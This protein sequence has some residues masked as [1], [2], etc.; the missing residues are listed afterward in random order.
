MLERYVTTSKLKHCSAMETLVDWFYD[1]PM[2]ISAQEYG[3]FYNLKN[4]AEVTSNDPGSVLNP[5]ADEFE[6]KSE[7][8]LDTDSVWELSPHENSCPVDG[9]V[10]MNGDIGKLPSGAVFATTPEPGAPIGPA[11][12]YSTLNGAAEGAEGFVSPLD[13]ISPVPSTA[14]SESST[15]P[16]EQLKQML[17]SQLEY[18]FSRENLANDAYLISQMDNDQYV[19]IW[20]VA[21]FNQVKKLTKDIKLIT[22][23]LRESPNVQV[24]E[25]GIKVRPNHKR[26]IV[27]LR[28]IPDNTPLEEVKNLF[29]GENCPRLISC[30]FAHNSSWY[31]TFESDEDAQ[32]A[33]RFLRE[34]VREFQGR[35][36]MARIKAK[37]M[38]RLPL[39]PVTNV[40]NGFRNTPPP[41]AVYDPTAF[42]PGQQ[43]FV[44]SNGTP[45]PP[46]SVSFA[47]QVH[48][49]PYQQ[50]YPGVLQAWPPAS[51][52]YYDIGSV[53]SVNGLAPQGTF[54][55]APYRT[56]P[57][58][59]NKQRNMSVQNHSQPHPHAQTTPHSQPPLQV[60]PPYHQSTSGSGE[61]NRDHVG[62]AGRSAAAP[63]SPQAQVK[64][65]QRQAAH[66]DSSA[67]RAALG[68]DG[69]N[70]SVGHAPG[71]MSGRT[72]AEDVNMVLRPSPATSVGNK[73]VLP[74][75]HRRGRRKD[76]DLGPGAQQSQAG[77]TQRDA[78]MSRGAQFDLE[79]AAFPPL[80]GLDSGAQSS[81][82]VVAVEAPAVPLEAHWGENRLADVVKGTV[83]V[84]NVSS[85]LKEV[86]VSSAGPA[87][88]SESPRALSPHQT[89]QIVSSTD[90]I[91]N[92]ATPASVTA[93]PVIGVS[94]EQ[95]A[96]D[97]HAPIAVTP[98]PSPEKLVPAAV[99]CTMADKS[100]KTDE[101][102]LNGDLEPVCP[103]TTNAAT[104]TTLISTTA[105]DSPIRPTV[106]TTTSTST[107]TSTG[108]VSVS[109][110]V[111]TSAHH[112]EKHS[113]SQQTKN[114]HVPKQPPTPPP[115]VELG[116]NPPR[117]SYAQVAQ[118]HKEKLMREK[119]NEQDKS[120]STTPISSSTSTQSVAVGTTSAS[121]R[122]QPDTNSRREDHSRPDHRGDQRDRDHRDAR[123]SGSSGGGS[124]RGPSNR[125]AS[126]GNSSGPGGGSSQ[127]QRR[128]TVPEQRPQF[129]EFLGS[130]SP[131]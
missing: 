82:P 55:Q 125:S 56:N 117:M 109:A 31:V 68:H 122:V 48:V 38:N 90:S 71:I 53:F 100:T 19:P 96:E 104:M 2:T 23:V 47:N 115:P 61:P 36:I 44:Y 93:A 127:N 70:V 57:R 26:C 97:D 112:V 92:E 49:Y 5:N 17:S 99:K 3:S 121:G 34:E 103:T 27:I 110:S 9:Y 8:D 94:S 124:T 73:D 33:Y 1:S 21:N 32:R 91:G 116:G 67:S 4:A 65:Q 87:D 40:K 29:N 119:Q 111:S 75:R 60:Q 131:K 130:R 13:G 118:H 12:D 16:L 86:T 126:Y 98:P 78:L 18:Y 64:A 95:H 7:S 105:C 74:P 46:G 28:E 20:T 107:N 76:E 11:T 15:I 51:T 113:Q 129:R 101:S 50:F 80:P 42:T 52:P 69:D 41:P 88:G 106:S 14:P 114:E 79:E 108:R 72:D 89:S 22:E 77:G 102:L 120:T 25:E 63:G 24:D 35:P 37:P 59:R 54:K 84:K 123:Y 62:T 10:Y 128:R 58:P 6:V 83:K 45:A 39:P 66:G 81:K 43:R 30:E 85:V